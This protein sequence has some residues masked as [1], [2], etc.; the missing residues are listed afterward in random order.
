MIWLSLLAVAVGGSSTSPLELVKVSDVEHRG[1]ACLD[2]SPPGYFIRRG[3]VLGVLDFPFVVPFL[4]GR[5]LGRAGVFY[6]L[7]VNTFGAGKKIHL[8]RPGRRVVLGH[9]GAG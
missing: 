8:A 2:G 9:G 6:A 5:Q 4:C 7:I 1:A 3:Q